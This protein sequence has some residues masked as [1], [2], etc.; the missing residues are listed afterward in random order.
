MAETLD[1]A[2]LAEL[3]EAV[4]DDPAFVDELVDTFLAEAPGFMSAIDGAVAAGDAGALLVPAHTLK[5]N[6]STIGA[7]RLAEISRTLEER[8]R[9]G[10]LD[11]AGSDAAAARAELAHV[12]TA[13]DAQRARRWTA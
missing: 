2:V 13:L 11:G 9:R 4:G 8:A 3:L 6:A 5:G 12:V 10:D 7:G 1:A